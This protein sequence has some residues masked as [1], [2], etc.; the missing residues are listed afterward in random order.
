MLDYSKKEKIHLFKIQSR[1]NLNLNIVLKQTELNMYYRESNTIIPVKLWWGW[2]HGSSG[3]NS[4]RVGL[5]GV[6]SLGVSSEVIRSVG[7]GQI[8]MDGVR[9]DWVSSERVK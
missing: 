9:S 4:D 5:D 6:R 7:S 3:D 1:P 8:R 2:F